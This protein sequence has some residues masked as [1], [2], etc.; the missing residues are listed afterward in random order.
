MRARGKKVTDQ[1]S[2]DAVKSDG[3]MQTSL[4]QDMPSIVLLLL[5]YTLQGIPMG[6][7]GSVPFL[8]SEKKVSYSE[9]ALFSLVSWPFSLKLFWAPIVDSIYNKSIGRR[10]SWLV[11][12]QFLIGLLMLVM[13]RNVTDWLGETEGGGKPDV[14]MLTVFFFALYFL[15]ATQDIAVDGWAITMLS[16]PNIGYASTCNSVG[17]TLGYFIAYVGFIAFND[18]SICNRYFRSEPSDEGLV[19]MAGFLTFWSWVFI[20]TTVWV[21]FFK[22]ESTEDDDEEEVGI[23][24]TYSQLWKVL[25]LPSVRHLCII[26]FTC[27]ISF[28]PADALT[29]LKLN[30]YG[31]PKADLAMLAPFLMPVG[32][33]IPILLSKYTAGPRPLSMFLNGYAP[34]LVVCL[35]YMGIVWCTPKM[36]TDSKT[37]TSLFFAIGFATF[38]YQIVVNM[39]FVAQMAFFARVS[40][41]AIG[42]TY[43]TLLNTIANLG[44]MWPT[45]ACLKIVDM[46]T[47]KDDCN[48]IP[49]PGHT[50]MNSTASAACAKA[51]GECLDSEC[52]STKCAITVD[53]YFIL[54]VVAAAF[55]ISWLLLMSKG[56]N[57]LQDLKESEWK[58]AGLK[59]DG[60]NGDGEKSV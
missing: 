11:P 24:E 44:G 41:P 13:S 47:V 38:L 27:K 22:T 17:Q 30:E 57:H 37:P 1:A 18:P 46:I 5:L 32:I 45:T 31:V 51:N 25:Q 16:R 20:G 58:V 6:L 48:K 3:V 60:H 28:A 33:I 53:G 21:C 19:S 40:D 14:W 42:G 29:N 23:A 35:M 54:T 34:R 50:C 49:I 56:I 15:C 9:Q 12:V 4:T 43:M 26:L 59:R 55:G 2:A 36:V 8:L 7:S 52:I 10:K 39:M